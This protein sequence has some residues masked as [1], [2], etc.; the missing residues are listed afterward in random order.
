MRKHTK[1]IVTVSV[2][3]AVLA[4]CTSA[5]S[6]SKTN[7]YT[8]GKFTDVS[9]QW[10]AKEVASAYELGFVEGVSET[11]FSPDTTVTV[12]QALTMASRV[13]A[14]YNDKTI[15]EV[16]GGKWYDMYVNYAKANGIITENQFDSY[17]REIK[18]YETALLLEAASRSVLTD[19]NT[20][21]SIPDVP[22]NSPTYA[23]IAN[24]YEA[25]ILTGND[26]CGT[27]APVSNL[28]RCEM[29][30]M[31][32]RIADNTKRVA[33]TFEKE[34]ARSFT[35]SYYLVEVPYTGANS[36]SAKYEAVPN[37]WNGD[38]RFVL[39]DNTENLN[40]YISMNDY[41][42]EQYFALNRDI[43]VES[44]GVITAEVIVNAKSG[45]NG[46]FVALQ[47]INEENIVTVTPNGGVW[48]V[49]G[50]DNSVSELKISETETLTYAISITL[51]LDKNTASVK[52]NNR[53]AG[54]V[55][56]SDLSIS[57]LKVGTSAEGTGSIYLDYAEMWKNHPINE[58]F[59]VPV[60]CTL[61]TP[62]GWNV[63]GNFGLA[64]INSQFA[65]ELFSMKSETKAGEVSTASTTFEAM[66]GPMGLEAFVLFPEI[67][68]GAKVS[69]T[70][71]GNAVFTFETKNGKLYYGDIMVNDYIANIWQHLQLD[72]DT[73]TGKAL[74]K[75]NG[76]VR[77]E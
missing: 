31:A 3:L 77:A 13:H 15:A 62:L 35:D 64:R 59:V 68:D 18:R 61:E 52:I 29:A 5:A 45:D 48:T 65:N 73:T 2:L 23:A 46:V 8:D 74:V 33:K 32:V 44:E 1:L 22:K 50:I 67:T 25:G 41:S 21:E 14:V 70:S 75:V 27:F 56:T 34:P 58:R 20:V 4:V 39:V 55:F 40:R 72:A 60:Y 38:N 12:A 16:P 53:D 26:S 28:K 24:L 11:Q 19:I 51:D 6:F 66:S 76:K 42:S 69:F 43:N 71:G 36:Q 7:T 49:K 30:A 10:Y 54:S 57:R 47:D 9:T 37:G 63:T 17:T